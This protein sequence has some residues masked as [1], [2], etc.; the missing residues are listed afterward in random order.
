MEQASRDMDMNRN[1]LIELS[2]EAQTSAATID[3]AVSSV[4]YAADLEPTYHTHLYSRT[5]RYALHCPRLLFRRAGP[6]A[7]CCGCQSCEGLACWACFHGESL[8]SFFITF[9][10]FIAPFSCT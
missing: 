5:R 10:F 8:G 7:H 6:G 9:F 4:I 1:S 2:I 3:N